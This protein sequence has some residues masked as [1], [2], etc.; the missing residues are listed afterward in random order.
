V[1]P[2]ELPKVRAGSASWPAKLG[3]ELRP[4]SQTRLLL[5]SVRAAPDYERVPPT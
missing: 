3:E 1:I 4:A 5:S 2:V